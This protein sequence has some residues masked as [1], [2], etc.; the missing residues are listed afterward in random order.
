CKTVVLDK[1][2]TLTKGVPYVTDIHIN[3]LDERAFL[4]IIGAVEST[5]DHPVAKAIA[6]EVESNISTLST[7][8][9]VFSIPGYGVKASVNGN[10]VIIA[11]PKYFKENKYFL[12]SKANKLVTKLEY[13]GKTVMIVFLDES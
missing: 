6:H 10:K 12:P 1:T 4:E 3:H 7:A 2:G 11:N 9:D 5:L 8:Y 13:E